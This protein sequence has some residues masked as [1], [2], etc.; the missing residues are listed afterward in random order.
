MS[1][2]T[3]IGFM[4]TNIITDITDKVILPLIKSK[5]DFILTLLGIIKHKSIFRDIIGQIIIFVIVFLFLFL[6]IYA[7]NK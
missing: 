4:I 5:I 3:A 6:L 7:Y 1:V 2:G